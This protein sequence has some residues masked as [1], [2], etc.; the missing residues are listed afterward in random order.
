MYAIIRSGGK[1]YRVQAGDTVRVEKLNVELGS[2]LNLEEILLVGGGD[3]TYVG[4]PTVAKAKVKAVVTEH[5]K[6]AKVI[7]FKK[8][9]R[10]GYR[11]TQGHRQLFTSLFIDEITTPDG[12]SAKTDLKA[13]VIDPAKKAA[14]EAELKAKLKAEKIESKKNGKKAVAKKPAAKK[15]AVKKK[16]APK[17]AA[18]K[19]TATKK[20][21]A[22]KAAK[23]KT[24][25]KKKESYLR[26][27]YHGIEKS[28]G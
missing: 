5:G 23:K 25:T 7:V 2:E 8:K 22:K 14:R 12:D 3:K 10:Q 17:K 11:R 1:Q 16:A 24:A 4:E 28:R 6:G 27:I 21:T 13:Q 26:E 18:K 19:K 9:R 15:K 20:K